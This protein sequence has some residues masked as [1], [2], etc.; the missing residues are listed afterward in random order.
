LLAHR[1]A[2]LRAPV[3]SVVKT[4]LNVL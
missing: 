3:G 4:A 1:M 2:F